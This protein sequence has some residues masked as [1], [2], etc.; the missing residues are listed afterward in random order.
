[1]AKFPNTPN[2]Y[3]TPEHIKCINIPE[4]NKVIAEDG[5]PR[6]AQVNLAI[7]MILLLLY[8]RQILIT[9]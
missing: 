9:N 1:M 2:M 5:A 8:K 3:I 6:V 4:F 7:K